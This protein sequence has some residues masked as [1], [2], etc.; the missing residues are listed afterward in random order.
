MED[1]SPDFLP[2]VGCVL[3]IGIGTFLGAVVTAS[4]TQ[5]EIVIL[6]GG[7]LIGSAIGGVAI[8][9]FAGMTF[10][11]AFQAAGV[12]FSVMFAFSYGM[13]MLVA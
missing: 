13:Q 8:S 6:A 12:Y 1:D 7:Y 5:S 9:Y 11:R 10:K 2:L 3:A 4:V